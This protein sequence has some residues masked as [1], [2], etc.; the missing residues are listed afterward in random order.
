MKAVFC[1]TVLVF[2]ILVAY[3]FNAS[4]ENYQQVLPTDKGTI[5]VGISTL[6]EK[7]SPGNSAKLRIDFLNGQT[8]II[9]EHIDYIVTMTKDKKIVFGPIPLS[10]TSIGTITIPVVFKE[11]GEYKI[12]VD[13]QG[14]LFQ[15]IPSEKTTFSI[16]VG[17]SGLPAS[18]SQSSTK[19]LTKSEP[20]TSDSDKNA[21]SK[22]VDKVKTDAKTTKKTDAKTKKTDSKSTKKTKLKQSTKQ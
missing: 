11:K 4:A 3:P 2:G 6:P 17:D 9:Q 22:T 8:S 1:I 19:S 21:N 18:S 14:I 5:K 15:P 7:L 12:I 20:K 10:H 16:M 13:V